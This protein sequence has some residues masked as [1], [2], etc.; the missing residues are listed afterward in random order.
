MIRED[1]TT[2]LN[3]PAAAAARPTP[4]APAT[5]RTVRILGLDP[6]LRR[7]GWGLIEATGN[8]LTHIADGTVAPNPDAALPV[9]LATLYEGLLAVL[10]AYRPDEAAVEET[11]VNTNAASTL[12]LGVARG[13]VLV[14]PARA[15]LPVVEYA[16]NTV[17]KAV[18]GVG[19]ADKRQM[20]TM[21]QHLLPGAGLTGADA[22]DALAL[23]VCHAHHRSSQSAWARA[24]S[25]TTGDDGSR[26][27]RRWSPADL[28]A[29]GGSS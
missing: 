21:I 23:A 2:T 26:R 16:A 17:K 18:V 8:R 22:A 7:T 9:R 12:K 1:A 5:D 11:F 15:G 20:R 19:H 25:K 10:E 29:L 27:T 24:E 6:G 14:V 28:R 13:V 4:P 3:H